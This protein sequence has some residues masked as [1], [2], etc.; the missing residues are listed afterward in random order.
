MG[1]GHGEKPF[2]KKGFPRFFVPD[3][4]RP[5][6]SPAFFFARIGQRKKLRKKKGRTV[7]L[8]PTPA[9]FWKSSTKT[10]SQ[11]TDPTFSVHRFEHCVRAWGKEKSTPLSGEVHKR[12]LKGGLGGKLF[13]LGVPR[14]RLRFWGFARSFPPTFFPRLSFPDSLSP[15]V[16]ITDFDVPPPSEAVF[17]SF[18]RRKK[19]QIIF[20]LLSFVYLFENKP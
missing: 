14:K 20:R 6:P 19:G 8:R 16:K 1:K 11:N 17:F 13:A 2:L 7:R 3:H 10:L 12:F 9:S 5:Y 4:P 18:A 15:F